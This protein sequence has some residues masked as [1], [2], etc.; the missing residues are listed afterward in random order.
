MHRSRTQKRT[1]PM[2]QHHDAPRA[3]RGSSLLHL[4]N[5]KALR[6][7]AVTR[8]RH[9]ATTQRVLERQTTH[10]VRL[11]NARAR[12]RSSFICDHDTRRGSSF[13]RLDTAK[14]RRGSYAEGR[15]FCVS[16]MRKTREAWHSRDH[17]TPGPRR[18]SWFFCASTTQKHAEGDRSSFTRSR[19][20]K[21]TQRVVV[22]AFRQRENTQRV[23]VFAFFLT[24]VRP[25][26]ALTHNPSICLIGP[27]PPPPT[28]IRTAGRRN[29]KTMAIITDPNCSSACKKRS[30]RTRFFNSPPRKMFFKCGGVSPYESPRTGKQSCSRIFDENLEMW[31]YVIEQMRIMNFKRRTHEIHHAIIQASSMM[32]SI[33][34]SI[35]RRLFND[36]RLR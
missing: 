31:R 5:A 14:A 3:R 21:K 19:H 25:P 16:T 7:L 29:N 10:F 15:R 2:H 4:D 22:F 23:G 36:N 18:G 30:L 17:D 12:K 13:L 11:D 34:S 35:Q 28:A 1:P 20:P 24:Q 6:V 33:T 8:S 27:H 9:L 26:R 32:P